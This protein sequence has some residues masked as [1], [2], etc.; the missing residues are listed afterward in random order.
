[1]SDNGVVDSGLSQHARR[2]IVI[3]AVGSLLWLATMIAARLGGILGA[4]HLVAFSRYLAAE[5]LIAAGLLHAL[6]WR[7]SR[8]P[9]VLRLAIALAVTGVALPIL[10]T[11][12]PWAAGESAVN[13]TAAGVRVALLCAILGAGVAALGHHTCPPAADW[14][15]AAMWA[16]AIGD[17]TWLLSVFWPSQF[18]G[19]A[20]AFNLAAGTLLVAAGVAELRATWQR[21]R[22]ESATLGRELEQVRMLHRERLHDARSTVAGVIGASELLARDAVPAASERVRLTELIAA[23]LVRLQHVLNAD[24]RESLQEYDLLETIAPVLLAHHVECPQPEPVRAVGH[25]LATAGALANVLR[26]ARVHA[27]GAAVAIRVHQRPGVAEVVVDDDGPGI[28]RELRQAVLQP[29]VRG[30]ARGVPGDGLGLASAAAA[31]A[32][33]GGTLWLGESASGGLRVTLQVPT[34]VQPIDAI[35]C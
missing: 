5:T 16:I 24:A 1:M 30:S 2:V 28:P 6:S 3:V 14:T 31:L 17:L 20:P 27:P 19:A 32:A 11:L 4:S 34:L 13:V 29:G 22:G 7:T 9:E 15:V 12:A 33:Q 21:Q 35:A 18:L 10:D 25:P 8:A 23:E 26:N